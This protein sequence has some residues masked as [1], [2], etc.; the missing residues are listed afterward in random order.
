MPAPQTLLASAM[1]GGH[2]RRYGD[3]SV[4]A[5]PNMGFVTNHQ[6]LHQAQAWG[7][8]KIGSAAAHKDRTR[9][10]ERFETL[11]GRVGSGCATRGGHKALGALVKIM[12]QS[13]MDLD[14]W[15]IPKLVL[16]DVFP[17]RVPEVFTIRTPPAKGVREGADEGSPGAMGG[18]S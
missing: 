8:G 7:R 10:I 3:M 11:I 4:V 14:S 5:L 13:G 18:D 2:I 15:M 1:A 9:L 6:D 16:D 12:K 17:P